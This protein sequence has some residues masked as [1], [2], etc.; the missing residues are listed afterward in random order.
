MSCLVIT[1]SPPMINRVFSSQ[2][3]QHPLVCTS[4]L[5]TASTDLGNTFFQKRC[6][7]FATMERAT[8]STD[9][10]DLLSNIPE[11]ELTDEIPEAAHPQEF[12]LYDQY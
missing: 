7:L 1:S 6:R 11:W 8:G 3:I 12:G 5:I 10:P 4:P 9:R 2:I